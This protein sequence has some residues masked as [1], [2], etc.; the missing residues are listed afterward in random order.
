[1]SEVRRE[2]EEGRER[3]KELEMTLQDKEEMVRIVEKKSNGLV[4]GLDMLEYFEGEAEIF[5]MRQQNNDFAVKMSQIAC[6]FFPNIVG[7]QQRAPV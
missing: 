4:S 5:L 7:A 2:V 1:M 6:S 3:V